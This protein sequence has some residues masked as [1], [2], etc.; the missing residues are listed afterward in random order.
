MRNTYSTDDTMTCN[1]R[2]A[3]TSSY[4]EFFYNYQSIFSLTLLPIGVSIKVFLHNSKK[5][6]MAWKAEPRREAVRN[7]VIPMTHFA[8]KPMSITRHSSC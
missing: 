5:Q 2:A 3:S 7:Y 4:K 1:C 8:E 6:Q